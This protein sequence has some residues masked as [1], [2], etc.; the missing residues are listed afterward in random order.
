MSLQR[1]GVIPASER[2]RNRM[3]DNGSKLFLGFISYTVPLDSVEQIFQSEE[4]QGYIMHTPCGSQA[5]P[6]YNIMI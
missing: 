6:K 1:M 3:T 2:V 5:P 4:L